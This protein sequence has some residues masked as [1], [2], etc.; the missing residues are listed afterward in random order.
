M[1]ATVHFL[2]KEKWLGLGVII[3]SQYYDTAKLLADSLAARYPEDAV[4]LHAGAGRS[5]LYQR[6]DSVSVEYETVPPTAT[7]FWYIRFSPARLRSCSYDWGATE[8]EYRL[9]IAL[10]RFFNKIFPLPFEGVDL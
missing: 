2:D 1:E 9:Q 5:R 8:N 4:G 10:H 7:R 3:F 6:G